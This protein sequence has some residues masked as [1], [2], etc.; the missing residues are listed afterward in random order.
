MREKTSGETEAITNVN[1]ILEKSRCVCVGVCVYV[2]VLVNA[3]TNS[4]LGER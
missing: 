1:M 2:G 3:K 4:G